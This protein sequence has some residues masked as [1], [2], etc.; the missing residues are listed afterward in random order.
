M[1]RVQLVAVPLQHLQSRRLAYQQVQHQ[2][3]SSP[4]LAVVGGKPSVRVD[5]S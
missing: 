1:V 2:Q 5:I 3:P 4:C